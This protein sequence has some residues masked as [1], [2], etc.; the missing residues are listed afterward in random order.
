MGELTR[1]GLLR[2]LGGLLVAPAIVRAGS[3]MP[4]RAFG[5]S[6]EAQVQ[7]L[8][9]N[10]SMV[11]DQLS[12]RLDIMWGYLYINPEWPMALCHDK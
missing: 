8:A 5:T 11:T 10:Y 2:G 12:T 3:L 4:I 9:T 6:K 1:R 7:Q